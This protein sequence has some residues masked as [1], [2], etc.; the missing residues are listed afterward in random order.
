MFVLVW[1]Q[2]SKVS[3][4]DGTFEFKLTLLYLDDMM[5]S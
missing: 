5:V 1:L 2:L 3:I 4:S